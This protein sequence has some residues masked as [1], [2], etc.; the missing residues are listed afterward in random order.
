MVCVIDVLLTLIVY[1]V[2]LVPSMPSAGP[3]SEIF[4]FNNLTVHL[5]VPLL[6]LADY[7][8]FTR[9]GHLKYRDVY[10]VVIYPLSYV[11][12][13]TVAGLLGFVYRVS[14]IDGSPVRF[15]YFFFDW[16]VVGAG[17]LLYIFALVVFFLILSHL[18]YWIDRKRK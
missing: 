4:A 13:S 17:A 18:L 9:P 14:D 1:W 10:Y 16:D 6:C 7:A 5:I 11:L 12:V 3:G 15:P 2:M 8:L